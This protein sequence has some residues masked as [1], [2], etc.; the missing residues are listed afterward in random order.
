MVNLPSRAASGAVHFMGNLFAC[1]GNQSSYKK[2][3]IKL[4]VSKSET[5]LI[6]HW[7]CVLVRV[8]GQTEVCDFTFVLETDQHISRSQISVNVVLRL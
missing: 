1:K 5:N 8:P 6:L 7:F 2:C 4:N 3:H